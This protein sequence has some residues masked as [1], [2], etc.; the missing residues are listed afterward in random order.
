MNPY[1]VS[2]PH[3]RANPAIARALVCLSLCWFCSFAQAQSVDLSATA[4]KKLSLEDLFNIEVTSVSKNKESLGGAA[5]AVAVVTNEDIRRSGATTIADT[6]RLLPGIHVARQTADSWAVSSRGFSSINSEKLLVLSDTR[7]IY[8]PLYSGVFW[9]VQDFLLQDIER[10]EVV[11]GPGAALWGSNAVNGVINIT[12]KSARDTQGV[13]VETGAG[14]NEL[15]AVGAR[16]GGKT[17][18]GLYYRIFGRYFDRGDSFNSKTATSDDSRL[19]HLG[20]R[21]DWEAKQDTVTFQGDLY[22]A[23]IGKLTPSISITGR[24][25]PAGNL[26]VGADGGNVLGHWRHS[27]NQASDLQF[28][29]YYDRTH[30]NDPSFVDNLDTIDLDFQH[31]VAV[32]ARQEILWGSNYRFT[33]NRNAGK[34]IFALQPTRSR[35]SLVSGFVQDQIS[36][37]DS[38][39]ITVGTKLEHNDFSGFELQPSARAAWEF[40]S[41]HTVW[42]AVSRAARVPTRL[43]RDIAVDVS[44]QAGT[45]YRL[46]GNKDFDSEKL[47]AYELG[48][49]GQ[50]LKALAIDVSAFHN[51]YHGLASLEL[52]AT[53]TDPSL[54]KLVG[55]LMN[56]NLTAGTAQGI[57]TLLTSSLRPYWRVSA[58][59]SYLNLELHPAGVDRNHGQRLA[60][61]TPRHHFGF[62]SFLDLPHSFQFDAQ[63]RHLTAIRTLPASAKPQLPGYSEVDAR[64]A[65]RGWEQL[66]LSL[67]GQ[68]LLHNHH[69]EFGAPDARGEIRRSVYAKIAWGF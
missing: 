15:A 41:G 55:P 51:R 21:A 47:T 64:L 34:V 36:I 58:S 27:I 4:L 52:G 11:R 8:T 17:A 14:S 54:G 53:F 69:A 56:Q 18:N 46:L 10:I 2:E 62:R 43:E 29:M 50:I 28:R 7:S 26:E 6:L 65:W 31:R 12:T 3:T 37:A 63:F 30:R 1:P 67:V 68:D 33:D 44:T 9:D 49:R 38:F 45:L 42:T 20:F 13:Y 24:P 61:S 35:D 57:E 16:Y 32:G 5:A 48:Y 66:E 40:S 19:G 22:R 39:R 60:G 23:N 59:H 25:G